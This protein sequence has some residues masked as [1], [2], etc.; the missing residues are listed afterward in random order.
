MPELEKMEEKSIPEKSSYI[1][2]K[3]NFLSLTGTFPYFRKWNPLKKIY[4]SGSNF[5]SSKNIKKKTTLKKLLTF[6]EM[7][8]SSPELK[9]LLV[10]QE[11]ARKARKTNKKS[12]LKKFLVSCDVFVI[13]TKA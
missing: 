11:V 6:W 4:I 3:L 8:L 7:E 5:P 9:I 2:Q 1:S 13:F 12:G 10:F